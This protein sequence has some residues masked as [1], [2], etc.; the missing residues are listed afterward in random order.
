MIHP[1]AIPGRGRGCGCVDPLGNLDEEDGDVILDTA[2]Y[3]RYDILNRNKPYLTA[4][5]NAYNNIP[6]KTIEFAV[7]MGA[8][9][10]AYYFH[11]VLDHLPRLQLL[12]P[13]M[14]PLILGPEP[15]HFVTES[16]ELLGWETIPFYSHYH[17]CNLMIP[18][19]RR[20]DGYLY[21]SAANYLK[22]LFQVE[23]TE[24]KFRLYI[25]R[26]KA[27]RRRIMNA[28]E[29]TEV[30]SKHD[31]M[32]F[33]PEDFPFI[34]QVGMFSNAEWIIGPHGSGLANVAWAP[35]GVKVLEIVAPHY[36]NPC[37]WLAGDALGADYHY[38][39]GDPAGD[40][41]IFLSETERLDAMLGT[42]Y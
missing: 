10:S 30:L 25:D 16:L 27:D 29:V 15:P 40:E 24:N 2:Y 36:T 11:W 19:T 41:D 14:P 7:S 5:R 42:F 35:A 34:A 23:P 4:A 26:S 12:E 9:W 38:L 33:R 1:D 18:T 22:K 8:A 32:H 6:P 39:V 31:V 13:E 21:P 17:V 20:K 37:C 28:M 3:G